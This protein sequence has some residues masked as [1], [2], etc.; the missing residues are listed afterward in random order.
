MIEVLHFEGEQ[1]YEW[2]VSSVL[3]SLG[4]CISVKLLHQFRE[5]TNS[6]LDISIIKHWNAKQPFFL[7]DEGIGKKGFKLY[8]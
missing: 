6:W 2:H 3:R 5:E 4:L 1:L 7:K 8:P